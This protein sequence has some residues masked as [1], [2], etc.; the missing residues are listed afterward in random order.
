M[1][2][3]DQLPLEIVSAVFEIA[4][5]AEASTSTD[6]PERYRVRSIQCTVG[7]RLRLLA[8]RYI[9][10]A[11]AI[12]YR[13]LVFIVP[14]V[15]EGALV[16]IAERPTRAWH[17]RTIEVVFA[18]AHR[19][20]HGDI[21]GS[22][23]AAIM[24][25]AASLQR[26]V[27]IGAAGTMAF[28]AALCAAGP[29]LHTLVVGDGD[30]MRPSCGRIIASLL[31]CVRETLADLH[32]YDQALQPTIEL[33]SDLPALRRL[34][35][36]DSGTLVRSV[37]R[38]T[39]ALDH[40]HVHCVADV[41]D[42]VADACATHVR[43][44]RISLPERKSGDIGRFRQLRVLDA[45]EIPLDHQDLNLPPTLEVLHLAL[46]T[47]P[48]TPA[49]R[50]LLIQSGWLPALRL[51]RIYVDRLVA[52]DLGTM[53]AVEVFVNALAEAC[54]LRKSIDFAVHEFIVDR[55]Y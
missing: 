34:R 18:E 30:V 29:P 37:T 44:L 11:E 42:Y 25:A 9:E 22:G 8:R 12:M 5:D 21:D 7:A 14:A 36:D 46:F 33:R 43:S 47:A 6:P 19:F 45:Y 31:H 2:S 32:I 20:V 39:P 51:V 3:F 13:S 41:C 52:E 1:P 10:P 17:I 40:L 27:M 48:E 26:V 50:D 49:L 28:A 4:A 23:V 35:V 55:Y 16:A 53:R 24:G 54:A 15:V 38:R